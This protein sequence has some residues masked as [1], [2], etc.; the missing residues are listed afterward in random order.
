MPLEQFSAHL[1]HAQDYLSDNLKPMV[2]NKAPR[3]FLHC[4]VK[5]KKIQ[6]EQERFIEIERNN[7][8]LVSKISHTMAK[9]GHNWNEYRPKSRSMNVDLRKREQVK[10]SLENQ[11]ILKRIQ[12]TKSA[13]DHKKLLD[14][15]KASRRYISQFSRYLHEPKT[16]KMPALNLL[17]LPPH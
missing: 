14:D 2:D 3:V 4:L 1:S 16:V 13:Y 5:T 15:F 9:G 10:V 6:L 8:L 12:N 7:R 17:K 11:V